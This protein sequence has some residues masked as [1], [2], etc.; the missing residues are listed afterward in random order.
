MITG[1]SDGLNQMI[2]EGGQ[3][4]SGG[5]RQRIAIVRALLRH[6]R[7]ILLDE[8]TSALDTQSELEVQR[9]IEAMMGT[10]TMIIVAHRLNTIQKADIV[11]SV[12]DGNVVRQK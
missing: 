8:A 7:I 11:Y 2:Q 3:N 4:L 10:C 5:Q 9:S 12:E 6:P 1:H